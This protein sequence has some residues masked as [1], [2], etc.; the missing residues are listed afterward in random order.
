M[1]RVAD[2]P[3]WQE[4]LHKVGVHAWQLGNVTRLMELRGAET[5]EQEPHRHRPC[6]NHCWCVLHLICFRFPAML[7]LISRLL[8]CRDDRKVDAESL[9]TSLKAHDSSIVSLPTN[10]VDEIWTDRPARTANPIFPLEVK[11]SGAHIPRFVLCDVDSHAHRK[12]MCYLDN[13]TTRVE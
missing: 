11:F 7:V 2:V 6:F 9:Q 8:H 12:R 10:L 4:F 13:R 3:T 5:G 1:H